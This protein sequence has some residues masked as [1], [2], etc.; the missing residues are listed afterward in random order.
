MKQIDGIPTVLRDNFLSPSRGRVRP[1]RCDA[2]TRVLSQET[3][4]F[5]HA[6]LWNMRL[7]ERVPVVFPC[8]CG[9]KV[10]YRFTD[11]S[12]GSASMAA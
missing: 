7:A 10:D 11:P 3:E 2:A 9:A 6:V 12:T 8:C 1:A 4:V 5:A